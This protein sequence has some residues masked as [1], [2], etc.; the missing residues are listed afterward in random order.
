VDGYKLLQLDQRDD[1]PISQP[2]ARAL[3]GEVEAALAHVDLTVISDYRHGLLSDEL[4]PQLLATVRQLGKPVFV[5]SQVAQNESNH[6]LYR[7]DG[8]MCLNL[9]EAR[10]I[11]PAFEPA[12]HAA[13]F[14]TLVREL[15]TRQIVVKLGEAGAL[16]LD[17]DKTS[18]AP[19]AKVD[20]VDTTGAGDAFLSAYCLACTID[21][22]SALALAN[23]WAGLAVQVHGTAPPNRAD[24]LAMLETPQP[25]A[26]PR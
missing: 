7:G 10:C 5:D 8:I 4:L 13:S 6:R 2:L 14:A 12:P 25:P 22:A 11:D 15:A 18:S 26:G 20:V 1:R 23:A 17:G 9:R 16:A 19:A 3:I 24:L 21:P